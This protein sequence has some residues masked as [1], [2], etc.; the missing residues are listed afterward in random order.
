MK[1]RL[2]EIWKETKK[3]YQKMEDSS[4]HSVGY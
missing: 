1:E 3:T 4:W 2:K